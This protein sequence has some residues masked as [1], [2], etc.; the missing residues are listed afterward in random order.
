MFSRKESKPRNFVVSSARFVQNPEAWFLFY[1]TFFGFAQNF[2]KFR[3]EGS[4][5]ISN[6]LEAFWHLQNLFE[7]FEKRLFFRVFG[8]LKPVYSN[9]NDKDIDDDDKDDRLQP[10]IHFW[11]VSCIDQLNNHGL[12]HN[13][14]EKL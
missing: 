4:F 1:W 5:D 2:K 11:S 9:D 13:S 12:V 10:V 14:W 6:Q 7:E 8:F 3:L